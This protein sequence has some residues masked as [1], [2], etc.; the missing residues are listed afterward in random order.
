MTIR[1]GSDAVHA[2]AP[3]LVTA[4]VIGALL[5]A[6]G[7]ADAQR[8]QLRLAP[9][10]GDTLR[11]QLEQRTEVRGEER[12]ESPARSMKATLRIYSHAV[13]TGRDGGATTL[14]AQTDSVAMD[15]DDEHAR[16]LAGQVR[17]LT[18]AGPVHLR[19]AM[20]GTV[21][22]L[23]G[24]GGVAGG[25]A[26]PT[27]VPA[28]LPAGLLSV[29]DTW[30]RTMPV[31]M[32]P[33]VG[34]G[35]VRA[36]FRLDSV[37]RGGHVAYISVRG[38]LQR[39]PAPAAGPRGTMMRV[40]GTLLGHLRLDRVRGWISDSRFTVTMHS[41]VA[42]PASSGISPVKFRTTVTQ[43]MRLRDRARPVT[44]IRETAPEQ[45]EEP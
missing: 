37:S 8:Y 10:P 34:A 28:A 5:L 23:D 29:G 12:P 27:V 2:A 40:A 14:L 25:L 1:T 7:R 18:G 3:R 33:S 30:V 20:D 6:P 42:P 44:R 17:Q 38:Q 45:P 16:S 39:E 11:M 19:L 21:Q 32:G 26:A 36:T 24:D 35:T 4:I 22:M 13:V 15:S 31:P 9:A 41:V 43:R